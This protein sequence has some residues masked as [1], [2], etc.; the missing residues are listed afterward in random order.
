M[1]VDCQRNLLTLYKN[2]PLLKNTT[3]EVIDNKEVVFICKLDGVDYKFT[4]PNEFK[5]FIKKYDTE[6]IKLEKE[7]NKK[8]KIK[9][10]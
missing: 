9:D 7:E 8:K 6:K 2:H 3:A 10:K 1:K 4:K 5:K